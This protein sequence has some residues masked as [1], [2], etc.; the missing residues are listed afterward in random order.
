MNFNFFLHGIKNILFNPVK[1]WETV[2]SEITPSATVRNSFLFPLAVLVTLSA[3]FG[4]LFFSN[5]VLSPVYSALFGFKC[6]TI[7]IIAVYTTSY[8]LGEIT[9]ALDL[10]RNFRLSFI[11][12]VLSV[13]PFLICQILSRLFESLL[14][15]NVIAFYGL[16]IF[17]VGAEK[18][19]N[20][21]QHKKMPLLIAVFIT[22]TGIYIATSL[23]LSMIT[24]RIYYLLFT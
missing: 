9:N 8:L 2:K 16:Y 3:Y 1:F 23:L 6:F 14:F 21:P 10:G 4:S 12:V 24:D 17:W 13:T 20:P 15:V 7:I 5:S 22:F 18:L 19:L 11:M